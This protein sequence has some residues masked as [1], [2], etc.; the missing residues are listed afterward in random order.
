MKA[1][2]RRKNVDIGYYVVAFMDLLGQQSK[3]RSLRDLP[4]TDDEKQMGSF[5][6]SLK[7]TYGVVTQMRKVFETYFSKFVK[8]RSDLSMLNEEQRKTYS[9]LTSN[10]I[11]IR[12][13]SDATIV[14]LSL[15]TDTAKLPTR[16]IFGILGAAAS[17]SLLS[18]YAGHPIRGGIDIGLGMEIDDGE[19]YGPCLSRAY[20]LESRIAQYPRVVIG[21]ELLQ[22]SGVHSEARAKGYLCR[23]WESICRGLP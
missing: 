8:R 5:I 14:Y 18:L 13:F 10:P 9:K 6:A 12:P 17:T 23:S 20:T 3:L 19:I 16:G 15:R 1:S 22:I 2:R 11:Q 4:N 7:E 21:K